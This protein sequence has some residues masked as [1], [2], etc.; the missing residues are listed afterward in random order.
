ME[1]V[2]A[3]CG[4]EKRSEMVLRLGEHVRLNAVYIQASLPICAQGSG[5]NPTPG[6]AS[7]K[8][9]L[10]ASPMA[11]PHPYPLSPIYRDVDLG[12]LT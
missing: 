4:G 1:L 10:S 12:G 5:S 6:R 11:H 2:I 9:S 8:R 3:S 7:C